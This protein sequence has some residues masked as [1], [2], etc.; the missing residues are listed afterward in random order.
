MVIC[1]PFG[2]EAV[3]AHR[4]MRT[5]ADAAAARG[6]PALRFD[7]AGTGD[8]GDI[9]ESAD[10]ISVW[11]DDVLAAVRVLRSAAGVDRIC[12]LG[13]RLGAM[14]ACLAASRDPA[15]TGLILIAPIL[16]GRRL[17][18]ELRALRLAAALRAPAGIDA[19]AGVEVG[20]YFYSQATLAALDSIELAERAPPPIPDGALVIEAPSTS[21]TRAWLRALQGTGRNIDFLSISGSVQMLMA[22][23]QFARVSQPMLDAAGAWLEAR[24][25]VAA[26]PVSATSPA[27]V[28]TR[29]SL[30][31][32]RWTERPLHI[33]STVDC[34]AI[35]TEPLAGDRR[36]RGVVLL[37]SGAE[38]HVGSSRLYVTLARRWSAEGYTV[39][40]IDLA[41]IG[42]SATPPGRADDQVF[43]PDAVTNV[44]AAVALLREGYG[45]HDV[46]LA[47]LCSGAYHALRGALEGIA[48]TRVLLINPMTYSWKQGMTPDDMHRALEVARSFEYYRAQLLSESLWNKVRAGRLT[49]GR[50]L[51]VLL[52]RPWLALE[53][54]LRE[55]ARRIDVRFPRD[56]ASDLEMLAQQGVRL[57]FI[58]SRGEPG[59]DRLLLQCRPVL[60]RLGARARVHVI[61]TADHI[62]SRREARAALIRIAS[63]ELAAPPLARRDALQETNRSQ[64]CSTKLL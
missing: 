62:F 53:A 21:N 23:P 40:R 50:I 24:H 27:P 18:R 8:S 58:F 20:G 37:N 47:G 15:V 7:Y 11:V 17:L 41:G 61:D 64:Q 22:D 25:E 63:E 13:L 4:S 56:L 46:C 48:A 44:R 29:S 49:P 2:Y 26:A 39:L 34:F 59:L 32:A 51:R 54:T 57:A 36:K 33:A 30:A 12:L 1:K 10:Q 55:W 31:A 42:D 3:C 38:L 6:V 16:S 35:V 43:P 28:A 45:I 5:F 14:L 60:R 19:E 52:Y 9:D